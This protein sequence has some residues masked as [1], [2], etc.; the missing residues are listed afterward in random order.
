MHA[1]LVLLISAHLLSCSPYS[2][3]VHFDKVFKGFWRNNK[4]LEET[5]RFPIGGD[6]QKHKDFQWF[7]KVF[8]GSMLACVICTLGLEN[9]MANWSKAASYGVSPM[10]ISLPALGMV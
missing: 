8:R 9:A 1:I 6:V 2:K 5:I 7:L 4:I 10:V 3:I